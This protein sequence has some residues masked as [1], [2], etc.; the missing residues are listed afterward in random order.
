MIMVVSKNSESQALEHDS[1]RR[2]FSGDHYPRVALAGGLGEAGEIKSTGKKVARHRP[3]KL[4]KTPKVPH[5][6]VAAR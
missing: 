6:S 3:Q 2:L 5:S 1:P 4:T